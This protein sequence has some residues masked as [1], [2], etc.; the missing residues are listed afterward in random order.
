MLTS[1]SAYITSGTGSFV[2][3]FI[4]MTQAKHNPCQL[5]IYSRDETKQW[6]ISAQARTEKN[7]DHIGKGK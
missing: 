1:S 7:R 3:I 6:K 5:V 4:P 2:N